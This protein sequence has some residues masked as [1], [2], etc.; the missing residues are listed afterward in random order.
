ME[1]LPRGQLQMNNEASWNQKFERVQKAEFDDF[2]YMNGKINCLLIV[3]PVKE[4]TKSVYTETELRQEGAFP[5]LGLAYIAASLKKNNIDAR[6]IDALAENLSDE[7]LFCRI[8]S[9][10]PDFI[11]ITVLTQQVSMV[12]AI[13]GEIKKRSLCKYVILGG[14]HIHFEHMDVIKNTAVDVCVRGEGEM[15]FLELVKALSEG[16]GLSW[17]KGITYR[18]KDGKPAATED[19]P[20]ISDLDSISVPARELLNNNLYSAP[21]SL[22]G[23]KPFSSIIATRGCPFDCHFC[24]LTKMWGKQRRR[25]VENVLDEIEELYQKYGVRKI[26]F[27]DDLLVLN[28]KWA[29]D[30]CAGIINRGLHKKI[31]WDCCGRIN[32]MTKELL[33]EMKKAGCKCVIYGIEFGSQRM[34]DFVKKGFKVEDV[35]PTVELTNRAGI[36]VKGLFMMGY[37]TETKETLQATINLAKSLKMDYLAVS[38]VAPYPGTDLYNHCIENGL[39]QDLDWIDII[40]LRFKAIKLEHLSIE[41][42]V[43]YSNKLMREYL[44]R[45]SYMA[46]IAFRHPRA[47]AAFGPKIIRTFLRRFL[48]VSEIPHQIGH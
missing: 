23:G 33:K 2:K 7:E 20:F 1:R 4:A 12:L 35:E 15:T 39:L 27:I 17:I 46:R 21:I 22:G 13:A 38:I 9:I 11:G 25:S 19:R 8:G 29:M 44:M 18:G 34:L 5:P 36:P 32:M 45:P 37:P 42:V 3:P 30:L 16:K 24:S 28:R 40:Q 14:P 41:D 31:M 10:K 47:A 26:S 6:I 43:N 48:A